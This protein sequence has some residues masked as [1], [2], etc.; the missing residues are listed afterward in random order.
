MAGC[1]GDSAEDRYFERQLN[2]HLDKQDEELDE[3]EEE[4]DDE[5]SI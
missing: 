3:L 4:E 1:Y 5:D 2:D